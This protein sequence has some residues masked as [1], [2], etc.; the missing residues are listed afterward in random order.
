M[1]NR[2]KVINHSQSGSIFFCTV[3]DSKNPVMIHGKHFDNQYKSMCECMNKR[4]AEK[5]VN[6]LNMN[7]KKG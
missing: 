5:I 3:I 1:K 4:D 6:A 2:Y 7:Y